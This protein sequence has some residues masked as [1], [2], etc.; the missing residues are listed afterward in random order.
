MKWMAASLALLIATPAI[1]QSAPYKLIILRGNEGITTA[2]Y[3][4]AA[5]C[6]A[7]RTAIQRLVEREN[8]GKEAQYLPNGGVI[9]P[10]KLYLTAYCIPG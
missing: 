3:P 10:S 1:A 4:S 9:I 8:E 2:D 5:R 7:A 6:E